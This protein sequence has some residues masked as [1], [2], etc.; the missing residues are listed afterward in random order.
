M[1]RSV[2]TTLLTFL[3]Y[4]YSLICSFILI[5][6][7]VTDCMQNGHHFLSLLRNTQIHMSVKT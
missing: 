4:K 7:T 5:F 2:L 3:F 6:L 1:L